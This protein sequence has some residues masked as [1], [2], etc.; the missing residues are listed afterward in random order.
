MLLLC[1]GEESEEDNESPLKKKRF[2]GY[3]DIDDFPTFMCFLL[4]ESLWKREGEG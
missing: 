2:S 4:Y 3:V 1:Y